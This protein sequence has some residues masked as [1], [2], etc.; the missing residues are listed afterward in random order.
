[1]DD[2][3]RI[4]IY[5]RASPFYTARIVSISYLN[6]YPKVIKKL[7]HYSRKNILLEHDTDL[8]LKA[9]SKIESS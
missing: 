6:E 7:V 5:L 8:S 2:R 1:M 9:A 4:N 3:S